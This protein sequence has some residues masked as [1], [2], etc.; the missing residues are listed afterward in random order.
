MGS[1]WNILVRGFAL[2]PVGWD[3]G[4]EVPTVFVHDNDGTVWIEDCTIEGRLGAA[5]FNGVGFDLR[6]G[7][8]A[9]QVGNDVTTLQPLT[10]VTLQRCTLTGGDGISS[11]QPFGA[12]TGASSGGP[13]LVTIGASVSLH[14]CTLQGGT[15]GTGIYFAVPAD[16][17]DG[18]L[19]KQSCLVFF[20]GCDVRGGDNASNGPLGGFADGPGNGLTLAQ[21][22]CQG[23][24]RDSSFAPGTVVPH[25][26][27]GVAIQSPPF[28]LYSLPA[29]ARSFSVTSPVQ[30]GAPGSVL[31][32]GQPGDFALLIVASD[33][34]EFLMTTNQGML[35]A[36][37]FPVLHLLALGPTDASG[38]LALGF[39]TPT[40]P[41]SVSG[42]TLFMQL[43]LQ[44]GDGVTLE[45][46]SAFV[47]LDG[48]L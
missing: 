14:D 5:H 37:P 32:D 31:V 44:S 26:T 33:A 38:D 6:A 4:V 20:A 11:S 10:T 21:T 36:N 47:W 29:A 8:P 40:L 43:V 24:L 35:I 25:G 22:N 34:T 28:T 39:T 15:A 19:L 17:G 12:D 27:P 42:L 46:G 16:G 9:V 13:A 2:G 3:D 23:V 1:G 45:A 18:A 48:S 30:E 7:S 41:A